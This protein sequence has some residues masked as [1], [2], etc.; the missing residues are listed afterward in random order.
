M[1]DNRVSRNCFVLLKKVCLTSFDQLFPRGSPEGMLKVCDTLAP[2]VVEEFTED[3]IV[4]YSHLSSLL[5][6]D[7]D[8]R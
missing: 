3:R 5:I 6:C 1:P 2:S 8:H 7:F 4:G